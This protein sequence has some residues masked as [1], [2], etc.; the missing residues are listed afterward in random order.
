MKRVVINTGKIGLVYKNGD[1][2]RMLTA[3]KYWLSPFESVEVYD[4]AQAFVPGGNLNLY[5]QDEQLRNALIL[6]DVADNEIALRFEHD[7]FKSVLLPGRYAYWKGL[8]EYSFIKADLSKVEIT[9]PISREILRKT[10]VLPYIRAYSVESYEKGILFIDGKFEKVLEKGEYLFWKNSTP[11]NVLKADMR[12]LQMEVSGQ[13]ILTKD[14]AALRVNFYTQ[15]KVTDIEKALLDNKEFE[16]QLYV[17]MQLALREFIGTLTLDE[18]LEKKEAVAEYVLSAVKENAVN[19]GVK[20]SACGI[21]DIIL[22]GEVK[23]IMNQVLVAEKKAQANVI[24][25]R[26]ETAST[27][28]LLNTAKLMEDNPML[29]KLKEMEYTEK[30]AEKINSISLSGGNQVVDQ[31]KEIFS[32]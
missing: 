29:F 2:K 9:E 3:G 30:I 13:E 27:R 8:V 28:S 10:L 18:L 6:V 16:K 14:K 23:E 7:N 17:L 21:R 4:M 19:L 5:L 31:L 11:I 32:R 25:R 26:E 22:P 12:Q 1:Y 24:T 20:V 15:Y